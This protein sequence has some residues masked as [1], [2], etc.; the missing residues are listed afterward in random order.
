MGQTASRT[1]ARLRT[2][3]VGNCTDSCLSVFK[4]AIE[5]SYASRN[6]AFPSFL[7]E[8]GYVPTSLLLARQHIGCIEINPAASLLALRGSRT[9]AAFLPI[10]H[11]ARGDS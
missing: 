4:E 6:S 10:L 3:K 9:E 5:Q 1:E 11:R 7:P 8:H 2:V